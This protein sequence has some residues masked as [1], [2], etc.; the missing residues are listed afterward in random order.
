M[1][2]FVS[3]LGE[4]RRRR[5]LE[6]RT[7]LDSIAALGWRDFERL[8]GEA[9]RRQGYAVEETGLGGADG[10]IDLILR[11]DGKRSLVQCKRWRREKVPV[12]VVREDVRPAGPPPRGRG[13]HRRARRVHPG[14]RALR[15]RKTD[16]ADRRRHSAGDGPWRAGRRTPHRCIAGFDAR[17]RT[18]PAVGPAKAAAAP[19]VP[20]C[21]RC[22]A[23]M[24][25]RTNR[26]TATTFW[27]CPAFPACRGTR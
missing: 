8:V 1:A 4:R 14:G 23:A 11:R 12:N 20:N 9:F 26:R 5:R 24:I 22:G 21:P 17:P 10:G 2:S 6:T 15:E 7:G 25:Q 13:A 18:E 19:S 3:F 27:G 16:R